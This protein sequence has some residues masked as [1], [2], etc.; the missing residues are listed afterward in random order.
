MKDK[1]IPTPGTVICWDRSNFLSRYGDDLT[2]P[3]TIDVTGH[4][5][6]LFF[7]PYVTLEAGLWE[8]TINLWLCPDAASWGLMAD[9]FTE[10]ERTEVELPRS[11]HGDVDIRILHSVNATR[12]AE[13]RLLLL[14]PAFHGQVCLRG[15]SVRRL[16]DLSV[17]AG[18]AF[19]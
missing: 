1:K 17:A 13:V 11:A 19:A 16:G 14:R 3:E 10:D 12:R 9:F 18:D 4:A 7:G 15:V 6:Y 2:C 8:A 5:R